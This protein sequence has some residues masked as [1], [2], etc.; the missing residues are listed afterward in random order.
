MREKGM[1][2]RMLDDITPL[3][4]T[5]NE[6]SNIGRTLER[7][8]WARDV[9]VVD[10]FSTDETLE[11]VAGFPNVRVFQREFDTHCNQWN[12]GLRETGIESEWVLALDADYLLTPEL[13][14]ELSTLRTESGTEGYRARFVYCINGR[15]LRG[16]AYPPVTVLYRR[17]K[18]AYAQDGHTQRLAL[19]GEIKDLNAPILHD[20]RKPLSH[21]V[22]AQSLY[23]K[24]EA[25]K[26][27]RTGFRD[28]AWADRLRKT[29]VLSP[30]A[31]FI[32]CL[33]V[34]GAILN[35]RRGIFYALQRAFAEFLLS[36]YLVEHD[37]NLSRKTEKAEAIQDKAAEIGAQPKPQQS[38]Q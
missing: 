30:P 4:L 11:I 21:W 33:F 35:G 28:L 38:S 2:D 27:L 8:C 24:L 23:M 25:D 20:D 18:S 32:Y 13:I 37:L 26:L 14:E 22:Q 19:E 5:Y 6:A 10:S 12:F 16:S 15:P 9:V 31:I 3:I 29:R 17:G 34:K 36:L 1:V 7:L